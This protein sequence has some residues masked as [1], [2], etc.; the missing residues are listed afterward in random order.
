MRLFFLPHSQECPA[1]TPFPAEKHAHKAT[2]Y[3]KI[4]KIEQNFLLGNY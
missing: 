4:D 1:K 2:N 3:R